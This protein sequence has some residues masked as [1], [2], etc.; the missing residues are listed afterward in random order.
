M[1]EK[2][3]FTRNGIYW[4]S[5]K[6]KGVRYRESLHTSS[7]T[8]ARKVRDKRIAEIKA[9]RWWGEQ[10]HSWQSA[11]VAW[12]SHVSN[13]LSSATKK[14]Y[15]VSL[16]AADPFL[17]KYTIDKIDGQAITSFITARQGQ[18]ASPA[19]IR[20]DL[21]AISS[22]LEYAEAMDWR[23]GNPTLSKRRILRERRDPINLPHHADI[24]A[25][26]RASS[27]KFGALI[28]AALLTGCRQNELVTA[29]WRNFD[30][31]A[32]TLTIIGKGNKLR[33]IELSREALSFFKSQVRTGKSP[34][35]FCKENGEPFSQ[36]HSDFTHVRRRAISIAAKSGQSLERFRFHDLRHLFAVQALRNG[37]GIYE[38]SQHLGHTSV[39]TTEIYLSHLTPVEKK[40]VKNPSYIKNPD[41][42]EENLYFTKNI[43]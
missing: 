4:L 25:I 12:E 40:S 20:R 24:E 17:S 5:A 42:E 16:T 2:N 39:K 18:G 36:A 27:K 37:M 11:V 23:E 19:T 3:L 22:V 9:C 7:V 41:Y 30:P 14:R 10:L 13:Q 33:V 43:T 35:I 15:G 28:R 32:G 6:I 1:S 26:I 29:S 31:L 21:T 8:T 38:L 34:F